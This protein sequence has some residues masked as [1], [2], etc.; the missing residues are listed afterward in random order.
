MPN[1]GKPNMKRSKAAVKVSPMLKELTMH[2]ATRL[3]QV[4]QFLLVELWE[5]K[6]RKLW[7]VLLSQQ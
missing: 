5:L 7:L 4:N 6:E 2:L 3:L 1:P